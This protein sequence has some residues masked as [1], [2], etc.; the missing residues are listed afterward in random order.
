MDKLT[1]GDLLHRVRVHNPETGEAGMI[2]AAA[3]GLVEITLDIDSEVTVVA[4]PERIV[5]EWRKTSTS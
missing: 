2:T 4:G 3:N 5:D 1:Y